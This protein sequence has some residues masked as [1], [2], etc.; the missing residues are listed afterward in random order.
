MDV[1]VDGVSDASQ[2]FGDYTGLNKQGA[3][4][5]LGGNVRYRGDDGVYGSVVATDLGLDTRAIDFDGGREGL[6]TLNAGLCRDPAP[7]GRRRD[8][9]VPRHR[10][11]AR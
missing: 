11:R 8:D 7:P 5:G 3:Y 2:K 6:Y 1:G 9:A 10:R 4:L